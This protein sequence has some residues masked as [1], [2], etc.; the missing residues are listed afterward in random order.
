MDKELT[1]VLED[2]FDIGSWTLP[3]MTDNLREF[4][5]WMLEARVRHIATGLTFLDYEQTIAKFVSLFP[6]FGCNSK[7][8]PYTKIGQEW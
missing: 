2:T 6:E 8:E 5:E 4:W 1:Q 7:P 3:T